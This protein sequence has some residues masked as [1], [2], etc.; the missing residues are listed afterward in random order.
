MD[1]TAQIGDFLTNL[2]EY[3][4]NMQ[5]IIAYMREIHSQDAHIRRPRRAAPPPPRRPWSNTSFNYNSSNYDTPS[6]PIALRAVNR[7]ETIEN[8][9]PRSRSLGEFIQ[10]DYTRL[11]MRQFDFALASPFCP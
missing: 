2:L 10:G 5:S 11:L 3:N 6:V 1:S 7:D 8:R 4:R 9:R